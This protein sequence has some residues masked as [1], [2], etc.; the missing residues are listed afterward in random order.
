MTTRQELRCPPAT[1]CD[2]AGAIL[3]FGLGEG[4]TCRSSRIHGG[5]WGKNRHLVNEIGIDCILVVMSKGRATANDVLGDTLTLIH[6]S[7]PPR[8]LEYS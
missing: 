6:I 5:L 7:E 2:Y 8:K 4:C 1:P 3:V